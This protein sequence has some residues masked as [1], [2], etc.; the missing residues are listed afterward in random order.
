VSSHFAVSRLLGAGLGLGLWVRVRI[1]VRLKI[2]GLELV[3]RDRVMVRG[4]GNESTLVL[5]S[6]L[7]YRVRV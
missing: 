4:Y 3:F 2:R 5:G 1:R 6:G 7:R